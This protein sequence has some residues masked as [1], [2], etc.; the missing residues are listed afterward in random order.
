MTALG[1]K[2][3][4]LREA[5]GWT[6]G[7]LAIRADVERSYISVLEIGRVGKPSAEKLL[8]LARALGVPA[9]TL[10][11]VAGYTQRQPH[12]RAPEPPAEMLRQLIASMPVAIPIVETIAHAGEGGGVAIDYTYVPPQEARGRNL[13]AVHVRGDCMEPV[14]SEGDLIIVDLDGSP[15]EGSIV[16]AVLN[17]EDVQVRR[18]LGHTDSTAL[19]GCENSKYGSVEVDDVRIIGVVIQ[20]VKRVG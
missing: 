18:Y 14:A 12:E 11:A 5:K 15:H 13:R 19:L 4:E 3:K 1:E 17:H 10:Y 9:D 20:I 7:Q 2:I 8:K 16:V 6:Q